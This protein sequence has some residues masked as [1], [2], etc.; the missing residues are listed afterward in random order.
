VKGVRIQMVNFS[1]DIAIV[2]QNVI[3]LRRVLG[4]LDDILK[5]NYK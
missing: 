1:D 5:S 3:N 2:V 4:S